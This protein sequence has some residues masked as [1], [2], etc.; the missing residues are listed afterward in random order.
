MIRLAKLSDKADCIKLGMSFGKKN[1]IAVEYEHFSNMYEKFVNGKPTSFIAGYDVNGKI[2]GFV[3]V[4]GESLSL[5]P[6]IDFSVV[7]AVINDK[8]RGQGVYASLLAF[9]EKRCYDLGGSH[10]VVGAT[11]HRGL[12]FY[13]KRDYVDVSTMFIKEIKSCHQ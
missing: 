6:G 9:V 8:C 11:D 12:A 13:Y 7:H 1:G 5:A 2:K 4:R 10:L 3:M